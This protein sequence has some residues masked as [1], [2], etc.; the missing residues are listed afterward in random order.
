VADSLSAD[1]SSPPED[2]VPSL[3]WRAP[4]FWSD[5]PRLASEFTALCIDFG[6]TDPYMG[7]VD[8]VARIRMSPQSAKIL[9]VLLNDTLAK[10]EAEYGEIP[11]SQASHM[12]R[13]EEEPS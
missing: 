9:Q 4:E 8:Q 1:H 2:E 6:A 3:L 13:L 10:W 11:V 5:L 7:T 12:F